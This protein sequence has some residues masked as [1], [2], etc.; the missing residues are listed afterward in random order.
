MASKRS[1]QQLARLGDE[2]KL[3]CPMEGYPVPIIEWS[4][5]GE[6]IDYQWTRYRV[7]KKTLKIKVG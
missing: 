6:M 1:L 5:E 3:L 7:N 2:I 4:K